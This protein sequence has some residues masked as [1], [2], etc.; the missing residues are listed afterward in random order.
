MIKF[1]NQCIQLTYGFF[2]KILAIVKLIIHNHN[3][4]NLTIQRYKYKTG[5]RTKTRGYSF[6]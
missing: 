1:M 2:L 4:Y 6:V 3:N 5:K